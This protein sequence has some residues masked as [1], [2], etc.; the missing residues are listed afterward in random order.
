M[1]SALCRQ[2][3][4]YPVNAGVVEVSLAVET[5]HLGLDAVAIL[6]GEGCAMNAAIVADKFAGYILDAFHR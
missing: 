1:D 5:L 6:I 4:C 3:V 2:A